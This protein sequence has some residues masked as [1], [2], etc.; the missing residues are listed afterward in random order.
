M[1]ETDNIKVAKQTIREKY[2]FG[3]H[4]VAYTS[5][6]IAELKTNTGKLSRKIP[7]LTSEL[8]IKQIQL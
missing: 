5:A 7:T 2:P 6:E 4:F 1:F 3:T 8:N